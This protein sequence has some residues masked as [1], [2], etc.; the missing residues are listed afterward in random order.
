MVNFVDCNAAMS[1]RRG[2]KD[3]TG[4]VEE[5]KPPTCQ[6]HTSHQREINELAVE[7]LLRV[8]MELPASSSFLL[9]SPSA[10]TC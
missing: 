5:L 2:G 7:Q 8:N 9:C 6:V 3:G 10:L 1:V 4:T